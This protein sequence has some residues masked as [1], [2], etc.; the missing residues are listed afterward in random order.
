M[1]LKSDTLPPMPEFPVLEAGTYQVV[2]KDISDYEGKNYN[3]GEPENQYVFDLQV[4][5]EE[6]Q[7][8]NLKV[9]TSTKYSG[10]KPGKKESKL[11]SITTKA[12]GK[13]VPADEL[14]LSS[15]I[16]KQI[17]VIV[18]KYENADGQDRNK[19]LNFLSVKKDLPFEETK[20]VAEEEPR[21][22][23]PENKTDEIN[24]GDIPF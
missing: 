24:L 18:D 19:V 8:H 11:Y 22:K 7:G 5:S 2:I 3:T 4:V 23:A 17:Q 14:H 9:W 15:L 10:A 12:M 13:S 21:L 16:G 6:N 20:V 1:P